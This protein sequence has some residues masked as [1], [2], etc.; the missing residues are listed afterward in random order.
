YNLANM[1][2][3]LPLI[4][5][6]AW[7]VTKIV[8]GKDFSED[9]KPVHL[10]EALMVQ[11]SSLALQASQKEIQQ[12]GKLTLSML[13]DA[14]DFSESND[15]KI[16][17]QIH[18]KANVVDGLNESIRKYL[19]NLS[20]YDISNDDSIRQT[21]LLEINR[22]LYKASKLVANFNNLKLKNKNKTIEISESYIKA[23]D[24][25]D[26]YNPQEIEHILIMSQKATNIEKKLRKQHV[27][28]LN[29]GICSTDGGHLYVDLISTLERIGYNTRNIIELSL[30][31]DDGT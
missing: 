21:T 30:E 7:L 13:E 29:K 26:I 14:K 10:D 6:L 5:F 20:K 8:P 22:I 28:R 9:Y 31:E 16:E 15:S 23:M 25:I 18:E 17:K 12:L 4:G 19:Q 27:K 1:V 11:S 3:H 24:A 2:I